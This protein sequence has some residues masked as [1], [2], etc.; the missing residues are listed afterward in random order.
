MRAGVWPNVVLLEIVL[1]ARITGVE[2]ER[3]ERLLTVYPTALHPTIEAVPTGLSWLVPDRSDEEGSA[4]PDCEEACLL[5]KVPLQCCQC[6][7]GG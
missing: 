5:L 7:A 2:V 1:K 6:D 4:A 3:T